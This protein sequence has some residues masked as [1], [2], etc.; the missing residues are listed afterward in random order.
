M[1]NW[2][3]I[4]FFIHLFVLKC[5]HEI[6]WEID[7]SLRSSFFCLYYGWINEYISE[8]SCTCLGFIRSYTKTAMYAVFVKIRDIINHMNLEINHESITFSIT[9]VLLFVSMNFF[10]TCPW[11]CDSIV[12][13][14]QASFEKGLRTVQ[15]HSPVKT[16]LT[17]LLSK[18]LPSS[19][20]NRSVLGCRKMLATQ[21]Y[22]SNGLLCCWW[23]CL[24]ILNSS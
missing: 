20:S 8:A 3:R 22:V 7:S 18:V 23:C 11:W 12:L 2:L 6:Q 21:L 14:I 24:N 1:D 10:P 4:L 13:L 17:S 5:K 16:F 15:F 9:W 19:T